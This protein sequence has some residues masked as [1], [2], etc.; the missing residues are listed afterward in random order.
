MDYAG[1]PKRFYWSAVRPL[2]RFS[3][4]AARRGTRVHAWIERR[5]VGQEALFEL[6]EPPDMTPDELTGEPGK[7]ERLREVFLASRFNRE[8]PIYTERPFLLSI[9]GHVVSGRI[10]AIFAAPEGGWEVVDYKTGRRPPEDDA[11]AGIQLDVYALACMEV[12]RK[13]RAE[14]TLTYFYLSTGEEVRY[15]PGE[16]EEIRKR[17]SAWLEGIAA[18]EFDPTPSEQCR[19]CDFLSFCDAGRAHEA[20]AG[21]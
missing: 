21:R 19:W 15:E 10:D 5:S 1:C 2:P 9:D 17:V 12:W 8:R 6:D 16:P 13:S 14:L 20:A 4:P 11:L 3:G 18:G 7:E